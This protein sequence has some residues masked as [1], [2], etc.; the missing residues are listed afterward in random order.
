MSRKIL[1]SILWFFLL[2]N[3]FAQSPDMYPPTV[4]ETVDVTLFNIILYIVLPIGLVAAFFLY[5]RSQKKKKK[6]HKEER[7]K[8]AGKG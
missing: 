4:P 5:Q 1:F 6:K 3:T 2:T 7:G 8:N